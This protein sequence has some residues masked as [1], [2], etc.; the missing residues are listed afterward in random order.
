MFLSN[1]RKKIT[2]S[3]T[4]FLPGFANLT[5]HQVHIFF[6]GKDMNEYGCHSSITAFFKELQLSLCLK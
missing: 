2:K 4:P 1:N 5:V 3:N 6:P